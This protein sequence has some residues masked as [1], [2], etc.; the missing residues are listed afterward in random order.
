MKAF[1]RIAA[2]ILAVLMV[3][4]LAACTKANPDTA[5]LIGTW[6]SDDINLNQALL[7]AIAG[8]DEELATYFDFSD[9]NMVIMMEFNEDGTYKM[10]TDEEN[11]NEMAENIKKDICAGF[12]KQFGDMGAAANMTAQEVVEAA[13]YESIE[14][15]VDS[16]IN[17]T[18]LTEGFTYKT[19]GKFILKDG[20]FFATD[21]TKLN[22]PTNNTDDGE[23]YTLDGDKFTLKASVTEEEDVP[24][25]MKTLTFNRQ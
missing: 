6:K 10:Y 22:P 8:E 24:D 4:S 11:V 18:D 7:E 5:K 20:Y 14:A 16:S 9:I 25:Y 21:D 2:M 19:E 15:L 3:A 17:T 12:E 23:A 13:G 1:K